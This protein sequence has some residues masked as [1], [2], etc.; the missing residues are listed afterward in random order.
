MKIG[1]N[2]NP[3]RPQGTKTITVLLVDDHRVVRLGFRRVIED[4]P[5]IVVV[6]ET[7]D[8]DVAV[9]MTCQLNPTVVLMDCSLP[10]T[11]GLA[12]TKQIVS[13]RPKTAVLMCSMHAEE[14]WVKRAIEA[15]ARGYVL[16]SALDLDLPGVIK[17][18]AAGQMVFSG[19][20]LPGQTTAR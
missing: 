7:G 20:G 8:G 11:S 16:K 4:E 6:G 1:V 14:L 17:Q 3:M 18:V 9:E 19:Q 12:A 5:E 13:L 15:G 10:G 2:A